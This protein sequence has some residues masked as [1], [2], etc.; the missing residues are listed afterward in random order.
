MNGG[1]SHQKRLESQAE[2]CAFILVVNG[3]PWEGLVEERCEQIPA[4]G[5]KRRHAECG[6]GGGGVESHRRS[7]ECWLPRSGWEMVGMGSSGKSEGDPVRTG[8]GSVLG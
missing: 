4:S 2:W 6:V 7:Q 3:E 5:P 8:L 1:N